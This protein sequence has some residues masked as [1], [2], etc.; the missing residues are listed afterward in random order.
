MQHCFKRI[1]ELFLLAGLLIPCTISQ[2]LPVDIQTALKAGTHF[3]QQKGIIKGNDTLTLYSPQGANAYKGCFYI[4]NH[5]QQSFVIVGADDRCTPILGYSTNGSFNHNQ[6]PTNMQVWLDGYANE[7]QSAIQANAPQNPDHLRLW[8]ELL[9]TPAATGEPKR[10]SYLL[11][12]TWEQGYG[13][14]NYC[15]VMNGQHVVVGCV[16]TA[17]AQII[18][19]HQ[20][21]LRG[22][23]SK[24]YSHS[25]Y[26]TLAVDF[27]TTEYNYTLMPN[28]IRRNSLAAEKDMVSRL[29]YHCGVVVNMNYQN[30][31][32]TSGSG[33][34][35]TRVPEGLMHFGYTDAEYYSRDSYGNDTSWKN[36]IKNEIDNLRPIEYAG[37]S[38]EGGH[39]FVLDGYNSDDQY[40]FNWGWGGYA[41]G[42]YT[43]T[44]MQGFTASQEMVIN[45]KPSGWD[46]HLEHFLVSPDG[47][48]DGTSWEQANS[49][50]SAAVKLSKY[51][52]K[53]IWMKKGTYYGD[54]TQAY[55]YTL[56]GGANI[57]GGFDGTES[58]L[59]QRNP[60]LNPTII[61]G[62][63]HRA[64]LNATCDVY[65]GTLTLNDIVLQNGYTPDGNCVNLFHNIKAT[66]LTIQHCTS[67]SGQVLYLNDALLRST[68]VNH[69]S[70]PQICVIDNSI[71]RQSLFNN[72]SGD[73]VTLAYGR[74]V[75]CD[76]VSNNGTGVVFNTRHSSLIN[77]IVWNND[78]ALRF[79]VTPNDTALRHSAFDSDT[80]IGDTTCLLLNHDNNA[81]D[82]PAFILP[83]ARGPMQPISS[84]TD[85]RL[86]QGSVCIDAGERLFESL[87][88]G[89]MNQDIRCRNGFVDL[90]CYESNYPVGI[91]HPVDPPLSLYPNP[92]AGPL[93]INNPD[94]SPIQILDATGR[95][96][97]I[98]HP[99]RG[100]TCLDLN[101]LPNG[102]YFLKTESHTV[103]IIKK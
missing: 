37:V 85:W 45:I 29:C 76:I 9:R 43:L 55:A 12:S 53:S 58:Q 32:H 84:D 82:G 33:S 77:S 2:A 16:A 66:R 7:I 63:K 41:D 96:L 83:T 89:D 93:T 47:N 10:D 39:A 22:F 88:D 30:P 5:G 101:P 42:F 23:G 94:G 48:G 72:N 36:M 15:P 14:N 64:L 8:K 13:Y 4:F 75:N 92:T 27:D 49:N 44:T 6:L 25:T 70:A 17:M 54:T 24:S 61:D 3:L 40:H 71:M 21:P 79:S 57:Y 46:G 86:A 1:R 99:R 68:R 91:A 80:A 78:T 50:L 38:E 60:E 98:P 62:Q 31:S 100:Q 67:D 69:N 102:I 73:I 74:L 28:R 26:G 51:V 20:Y 19:Y 87:R 56:K 81:P 35:T 90:G 52:N 59:S 103:K 11:T 97:L 65:N 34:Y 95:V 18:R